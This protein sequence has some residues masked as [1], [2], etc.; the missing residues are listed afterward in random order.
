MKTRTPL[1]LQPDRF[2][3]NLRRAWLRFGLL[4]LAGLGTGAAAVLFA[5]L[6]DA[7]FEGFRHARDWGAWVPFVLSPAV[8]AGVVWAT[9]R[10]SAGAEGS[11]IPQVIAA[12]DAPTAATAARLLDWRVL[13]GKIGLGCAALLG[14]FSAGREGPSV[15]V[16][17]AVAWKVLQLRGAAGGGVSMAAMRHFV[18]AGGAAGVA[19]AFNA[20]LAGVV[21]AI[22]ELA[23]S[24]EHRTN[25]ATIAAVIL[26]GVVA[27]GFQGNYVYFGRI[28]AGDP[29]LEMLLPVAVAAVLC[30]AAGGG[31]S[32]LLLHSARWMPARL[33]ALRL[34]RPVWFAAGCGLALALLG[35]AA[36]GSVFGSGYHEA[37]A[38]LA[39][40][41]GAGWIYAPAKL[42]ANLVSFL[43]GIPG[44]LFAPSLAVGAGIG[45]KLSALFP[46]LG[47][48][49]LGALCMVAF[50]AAVTQSPMTA[51]V[52]VMEMIDN[53]GMVLSLMAAAALA[54]AVSR[55]FCPPLYPALARRYAEQAAVAEPA[56]R[57]AP[58][59]A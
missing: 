29:G 28:T 21:F 40:E 15:Q 1:A 19:A 6:A 39:G 37:R 23:R 45:A 14:G 13:L 36:G 38:L 47:P 51:F 32:W 12:L 48:G 5:R 56:R 27:L 50:L 34:E 7:A 59:G 43:S 3:R 25:G 31:F 20:P 8:G 46:G 24:F 2:F 44:G 54:T 58:V 9:R 17:A 30:G 57:D 18:A 49:A 10:W 16:G 53:H 35:L 11:G 42:L 52:I 55:L 33:L 26:A 4:W 22:E 41:P